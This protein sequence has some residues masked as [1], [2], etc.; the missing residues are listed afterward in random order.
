MAKA[1]F[2]TQTHSSLHARPLPTHESRG[3]TPRSRVSTLRASG[4][5][6]PWAPALSWAA[7]GG[8]GVWQASCLASCGAAELACVD[9][10]RKSH[11]HLGRDKMFPL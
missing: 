4:G 9:L 2:T 10:E 5:T 11:R 3:P 6:D 1:E 7:L 8:Q